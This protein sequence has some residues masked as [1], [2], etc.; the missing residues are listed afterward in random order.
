MSNQYIYNGRE[1]TRVKKNEYRIS[2]TSH[3]RQTFSS[4]K[5]NGSDFVI[6]PHFPSSP[7]EYNGF[8][9]YNWS[10]IFL[11]WIF[12][13]VAHFVALPMKYDTVARKYA[14]IAFYSSIYCMV[15]LHAIEKKIADSFL[16]VLSMDF[17]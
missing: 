17:Q 15:N 8:P 4:R 9:S 11:Y 6:Y 12:V 5:I 14:E 2:V 16:S 1:W 13:K 7:Y 3:S 10:V